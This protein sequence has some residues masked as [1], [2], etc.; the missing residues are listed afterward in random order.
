MNG[1]VGNHGRQGRSQ[2]EGDDQ[3][4]VI[5]DGHTE[6]QRLVDVEQGRTNGC[7]AQYGQLFGFRAEAHPDTHA[8]S[9]AGTAADNVHVLEFTGKGRVFAGSPLHDLHVGI[10]VGQCDRGIE[11]RNDVR[12]VNAHRPQSGN[13]EVDDE[14]AIPGVRNVCNEAEGYGYDGEQVIAD[15]D[16]QTVQD[17]YDECDDKAGN[18]GREGAGHTGGYHIRQLDGPVS[19]DAFLVQEDRQGCHQDAHEDA[20]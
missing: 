10:Q 7:L 5:D 12:T 20:G 18:Q 11:G 3:V 16:Q 6:D 15:A 1:E 2:D 8:Q 4:R 17:Q 9:R 14:Y 13:Q 19:S